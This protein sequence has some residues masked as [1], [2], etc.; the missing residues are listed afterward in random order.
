MPILRHVSPQLPTAHHRKAAQLM[1]ARGFKGLGEAYALGYISGAGADRLLGVLA[2]VLVHLS[3]TP[4]YVSAIRIMRPRSRSWHRGTSPAG[5]V[6]NLVWHYDL[7]PEF[8]G[9][10]LD[11]SMT[12]SCADFDSPDVALGAAQRLKIERLV[13]LLEVAPHSR[14]LDVG[15]GWGSVAEAAAGAG[16]DV[17]AVSASPSQI[18]YCRT[19]RSSNIAFL[20]G[21]FREFNLGTFDSVVSCEMIEGV[22]AQNLEE[23]MSWISGHLVLGGTF[24]LQA[25]TT[26]DSRVKTATVDT[27]FVSQYVFPGGQ[28]LSERM[29]AS[30][31][32]RAGMSLGHADKMGPSYAA[33]I[34]EWR[35]NLRGSRT[36]L[37]RLGVSPELFGV[38]DFYF[39]MCITGFDAGDMDCVRFVFRRSR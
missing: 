29:I 3:H 33:T 19:H 2:R 16:G 36:R 10:F 27:G 26:A 14:V 15:C 7:E 31:A 23:F 38:W 1:A 30:A 17:V 35:D 12:Y 22:G 13:S 6:R 39:S 5:T 21:D 8:F 20:V 18:D 9:V 11:D 24:V 34:R 32:R 37:S 4:G 25:I 28:I